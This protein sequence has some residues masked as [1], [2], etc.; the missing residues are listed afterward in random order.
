MVSISRYRCHWILPKIDLNILQTFVYFS[1]YSIL[2]WLFI[3]AVSHITITGNW[4]CTA[5]YLSQLTSYNLLLSVLVGAEE[6]HCLHVSKVNIMTQQ[7][8][9]E[10]L[11][12]IL[13]L[14]VAVQCLVPWNHSKL[15]HSHPLML[16]N[17][18][19]IFEFKSFKI[20]VLFLYCLE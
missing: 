10:E 15:M 2:L 9:E 7:E 1:F 3:S 20:S 11:T 14:L 4:G 16:I 13:L 18:R 17:P 19:H 12:H 5:L 8:N 6:I